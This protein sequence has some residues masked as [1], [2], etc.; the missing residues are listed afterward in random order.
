MDLLMIFLAGY[1]SVFALG[2]QS[3]NVNSGHYA[4]AAGTSFIIALMQA[5][6][7]TRITS[8]HAGWPEA[9][10]YGISGM[11]GITSSMYVHKRFIKPR[12]PEDRPK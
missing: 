4:W 11:A 1:A 8:P 9:I 10:T 6:I 3:R 12:P 2:F 7:W 5:S